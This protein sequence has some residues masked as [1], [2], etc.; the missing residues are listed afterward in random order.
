M[1]RHP[2]NRRENAV[3]GQSSGVFGMTLVIICLDCEETVRL[4][5]DSDDTECCCYCDGVLDTCAICDQ[6]DAL[7]EMT[8]YERHECT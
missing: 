6:C 2:T 5:Q 7:V 3:F 1:E 8:D 4:H